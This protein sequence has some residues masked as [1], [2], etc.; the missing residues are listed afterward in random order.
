MI[1]SD[2]FVI[3]LTKLKV[4]NLINKVSQFLDKEAHCYLVIARQET[5]NANRKLSQGNKYQH[6]AGIGFPQFE[7]GFF[8]KRQYIF[9]D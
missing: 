5:K 3:I 6:I 2:D 9:E 7:G 4:G 1:N 8:V